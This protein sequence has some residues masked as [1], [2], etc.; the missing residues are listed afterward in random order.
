MT[1]IKRPGSN[2]PELVIV[3]DIALE[4]TQQAIRNALEGVVT[5]GFVLKTVT[6]AKA[7]AAAGDYA[8]E[9]VM[10]DGATTGSAWQF[11]N[12][13]RVDGGSGYITKA[14]VVWATTAL[15]PR[16]TLLVFNAAPTSVVN[17]NVASTAVLPADKPP[18]YQGPIDL[19]ALSDLGGGSE[20]TVSPS[21]VGN[22]PLAFQCAADSRDLF[23]LAVTRDA[24]TG[25][26]D[27]AVMTITL[28]VEQ[29]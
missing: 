20:A 2:S 27:E 18:K 12:M 3:P 9:D 19:M 26:V 11:A 7:L 5:V 24:V 8:A 28:T 22:L 15:A 16:I 29:T 23:I 21:T 6:V 10:S 1:E 14:S 4:A 13:G 17:D 25:E